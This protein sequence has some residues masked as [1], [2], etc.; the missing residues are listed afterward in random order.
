MDKGSSV[1]WTDT[2][3]SNGATYRYL[4]RPYC[5]KTLGPYKGSKTV[6]RLTRTS[7]SSAK[8]SAS[9]KLSLAWKRNNRASGYQLQYATNS[10]F[11]S[12]KT[13]TVKSGKMVTQ[14][15][16][17]LKKG[18][19]YYVRVRCYNTGSGGRSYS[20]WSIRKVVKIKR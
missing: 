7:L 1:N 4:V 13:V 15:L 8:N 3:V 9:R 19:Q 2:K 6:Y 5:G 14:T 17:R 12:P 10:R 20:A 11:R 16:S 18:K